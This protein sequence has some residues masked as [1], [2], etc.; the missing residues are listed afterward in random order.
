MSQ[1]PI[2]TCYMTFG[3]AVI[4]RSQAV[5]EEERTTGVRKVS[6]GAGRRVGAAGKSRREEGGEQL[7]MWLRELTVHQLSAEQRDD[8]E[9]GECK[10]ISQEE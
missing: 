1:Q 8:R 4:F 2:L 7:D 10:L 6:G 9:G 5:S 3:S